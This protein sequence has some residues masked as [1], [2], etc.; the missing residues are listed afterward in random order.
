MLRGA[1]VCGITH[2]GNVITVTSQNAS[3]IAETLTISLAG[4]AA[5]GV[6][7]GGSVSGTDL[8]LT[9]SV[10]ADVVIAGLPSGGGS[11]DGVVTSGIV[12]GTT[13]TLDRSVGAAVTITGLPS[14]TGPQGPAGM[15]GATGPAGP[16]GSDSPADGVVTSGTVTG[17]TLTLERSV[18][19]NVQITGIGGGT[20][21]F[22]GVVTGVTVDPFSRALILMRSE[23]LDNLVTM[24]PPSEIVIPDDTT[25]ILRPATAIDFDGRR[26][27]VDHQNIRVA[28]RV[29]GPAFGMATYVTY[30][31]PGFLGTFSVAAAAP[32]PSEDDV[33]YTTTDGLWC[34]Y[35]S[36]RWQCG[37]GTPSQWRG[38]FHTE[39]E[40]TQHVIGI[41][42]VMYWEGAG[43]PQSVSTFTPG[44]YDYEWQPEPER[45]ILLDRPQLPRPASADADLGMVPKVVAGGAYELAPDAGGTIVVANPGTGSILLSNIT[46]GPEDYALP[47][48]V[49]ANPSGI[50]APLTGLDISGSEYSVPE[51]VL[52]IPPEDV[53]LVTS[54]NAYRFDNTLT[55]QPGHIY[56]FSPKAINDGPVHISINGTSYGFLKAGE[57]GGEEAFEGGELGLDIPVL[58]AYDGSGFN[59]IG[60][61][62]GSAAIRDVGTDPGDLVPVGPDGR[63]PP[64]VFVLDGVVDG[65]GYNNGLL[66]L[67]RTAGLV[68]LTATGFSTF[69]EPTPSNSYSELRYDPVADSV[70]WQEGVNRG[71]WQ[72]GRDLQPRRHR[73]PAGMDR[74]RPLDRFGHVVQRDAGCGRG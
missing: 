34:Q 19:A 26:L 49:T 22:D 46:I 12:S 38:A 9:R 72:G 62:L 20:G 60:A 8:T 23:S 14:N 36:G 3:S 16:A 5:D 28:T 57:G 53:V 70:G 15:D 41:G 51:E 45:Q 33:V 13:L 61:T 31:R 24:L 30:S 52:F 68:P 63:L 29:G 27:A 37:H 43:D 58:A 42:D 56:F 25:G 18:G 44:V 10:G 66:T 50:H 4:G 2:S 1:Y 39:A 35:R 73:A 17:T 40:A 74:A 69:P 21:T 65:V 71:A 32:N 47:F 48:Q 64:D 54:P 7:D 11:D 67:T 55:P 6:V 59:W